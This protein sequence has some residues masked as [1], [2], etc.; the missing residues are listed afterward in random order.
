M[1]N[2]N[3]KRKFQ[4]GASL[5]EVMVAILVMAIGMLGIAALQAVSLRNTQ[6]SAERTNA[7]IQ[8]YSMLDT[9][10]ANREQA[11]AGNYDENWLCEAPD[12]AGR[13]SGEIGNWIEQMQATVSPTACGQIDCG[14]VECT[15]EVR[16]NDELATGG[17]EEYVITTKSRL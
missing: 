9:M 3:G 16:W 10:R 12:D 8:S 6:G 1:H 4:L 15:V 2:R 14:T 13:I 5:I 7:I 11:R 17:E